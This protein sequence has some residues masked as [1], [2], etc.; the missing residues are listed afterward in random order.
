MKLKKNVEGVKIWMGSK[1]WKEFK[2]GKVRKGLKVWKVKEWKGLKVVF[3]VCFLLTQTA[4]SN[5]PV[6]KGL[7]CPPSYSHNLSHS[8]KETSTTTTTTIHPQY[9]KCSE[10]RVDL[11]HNTF[12]RQGDFGYPVLFEEISSL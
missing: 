8:P 4:D 1:V 6:L 7:C 3:F 12:Q 10:E 9:I 11:Q 5:R 2:Y